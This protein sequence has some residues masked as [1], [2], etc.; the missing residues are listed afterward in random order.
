M[1]RQVVT[2]GDV[3][4]WKAAAGA[5]GLAKGGTAP[6]AEP[7][8]DKYLE[9]VAKYVPADV[10]AAYLAF[11][12]LATTL[13]SVAAEWVVFG[14][15]L[16]MTPV[17]LLKKQRVEKRAQLI[18]ST[19]AYVFWVFG[20]NG[21]GPFRHLIENLPPQ[22]GQLALGLFSFSVGVIEPD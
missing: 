14:F 16:V 4:R 6:A 11:T 10:I 18:I 5:V 12:G 3:D 17:Y 8:K 19:L 1:T 7:V 20:T 13:D 15:L 9:R 2:Q 22:Y 21:G